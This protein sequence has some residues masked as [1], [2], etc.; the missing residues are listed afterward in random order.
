VGAAQA[1]RRGAFLQHGSIPQALDPERLGEAVGAP[2]DGARFIDLS[3][4]LGRAVDDA[5]LDRALVTGFEET[6]GARLVEGELTRD[7][8]LRA[9]ELRCWKYDSIAWTRGGSIGAREARWGPVA[10]R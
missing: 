1:R 4:A 3:R 8:S 2:V 5:E 6:F 10:A 9:A 7:E